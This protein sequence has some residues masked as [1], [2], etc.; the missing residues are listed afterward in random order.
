MS[1]PKTLQSHETIFRL[2]GSPSKPVMLFFGTTKFLPPPPFSTS[3]FICHAPCHPSS[4]ILLLFLAENAT[5]PTLPPPH[6]KFCAL[7]LFSLSTMYVPITVSIT[8]DRNGLP[9]SSEDMKLA[10]CLDYNCTGLVIITVFGIQEELNKCWKEGQKEGKKVG[11]GGDSKVLHCK[12]QMAYGEGKRVGEDPAPK[13]YERSR[14]KIGKIGCG[15]H[16][17]ASHDG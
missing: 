4:Q 3:A 1:L 8:L 7:F 10:S 17:S 11:K 5:N 15:N 14:R 9:T 16:I 13:H 2:P 12:Y 6:A